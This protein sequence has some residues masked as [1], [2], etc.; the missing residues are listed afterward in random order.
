MQVNQQTFSLVNEIL[1]LIPPVLV[2]TNAIDHHKE[3]RPNNVDCEDPNSVFYNG[4]TLFNSM[5]T[6]SIP[7]G[8][9]GEISFDQF[10]NRE[11]IFL[12][13]LEVASDGL[14]I[15]G[16]WNSTN[17]NGSIATVSNRINP[18]RFIEDDDN[19]LLKDKLLIVLIADVRF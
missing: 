1:N 14:Q 3:M 5:K 19:S 17:G 10:G 8:L 18:Y 12:E 9:T 16:F 11:N 15:V 4:I 2:F 6:V 7:N 13:V